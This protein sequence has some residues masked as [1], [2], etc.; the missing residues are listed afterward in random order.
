MGANLARAELGNI[1][2]AA[3]DFQSP[4]AE[5]RKDGFEAESFSFFNR[6]ANCPAGTSAAAPVTR[7]GFN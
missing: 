2:D 4:G 1:V 7:L 6:S 3:F 5:S